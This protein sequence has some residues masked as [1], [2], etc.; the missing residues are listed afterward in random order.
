M[1][2]KQSFKLA[3]FFCGALATV[4]FNVANAEMCKWV[5]EDGCVHYADQC[6]EGVDGQDEGMHQGPPE[7]AVKQAEKRS[8]Q[9]P[10]L[11]GQ[12]RQAD[13]ESAEKMATEQAAKST[14][15]INTRLC[16]QARHT[17]ARLE[18]QWPVY[19]DSEGRYHQRESLHSW[20]YEGKRTWLTDDLRQSELHLSEIFIQQNCQGVMTI[21]IPNLITYK[22]APSLL[23]TIRTFEDTHFE[24]FAKISR[25]RNS[26]W[27]ASGKIMLGAVVE[28]ARAPGGEVRRLK[29]LLEEKCN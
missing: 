3:R 22:F 1:A 2:H 19:A 7:E 5:D 12:H 17:I 28:A 18:Q 4:I 16:T 11:V 26:D 15:G 24:G 9:L 21:D 20:Y 23:E 10:E 14:A 25:E 6:P 29:E 8:E 27:C 13:Q